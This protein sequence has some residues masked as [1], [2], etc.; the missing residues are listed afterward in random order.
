MPFNTFTLA[1]PAV[2]GVNPT[3]VKRGQTFKIEG[4]GF[5]PSL[6]TAVQLG[7]VSL[8]TGNFTPN[9]DGTVTVVVPNNA[10]TGKQS[11][12][13]QTS[14]GQSNTDVEIKVER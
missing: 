1:N 5:Y 3:S 8:P 12:G 4:S 6:V 10:T 2:S 13:V 9:S 14:Q 11:V 7:G